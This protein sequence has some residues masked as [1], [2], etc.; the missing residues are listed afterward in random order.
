MSTIGDKA[1]IL[2]KLEPIK[3]KEL[4][5]DDLVSD[6]FAVDSEDTIKTLED[7]KQIGSAFK[8]VYD[9][10]KKKTIGELQNEFS[11]MMLSS[12][13]PF[14]YDYIL[15]K[16]SAYYNKLDKAKVKDGLLNILFNDLLNNTTKAIAD[17][18]YTNMFGLP[19]KVAKVANKLI[20]FAYDMYYAPETYISLL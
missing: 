16:I 5:T 18:I 13:I 14:N 7:I 12:D 11:T 1:I 17:I 8:A 9:N 6:I 15:E 20:P 2:L 4:E 10:L 3:V 19:F